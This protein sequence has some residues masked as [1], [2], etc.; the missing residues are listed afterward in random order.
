M[1]CSVTGRAWGQ[2]MADC[3]GQK[4]ATCRQGQWASQPAKQP[5]GGLED[6]PVL[7]G[8][9]WLPGGRGRTETEEVMDRD[10]EKGEERGERG[11]RKRDQ[12]KH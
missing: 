6:G 2:A 10:S 9:L 3:S 12:M 4:R 7:L 11:E 5:G 1:A 8:N